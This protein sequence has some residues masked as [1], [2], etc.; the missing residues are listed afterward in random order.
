MLLSSGASAQEWRFYGG[1]SG[2]TRFSSLQQISRSNVKRLKRTWTYHMGEGDR[3]GNE[4]DRHHVA[5]FESTPLVIDGVLYFSTPSNRVIALDA[6]SGKEIWQFDP[7]AGHA[8]Q[9]EFFQHRG[10]SYWQNKNGSDRRIL[11][12]TFDGRLIALDAKTGKPCADFGTD[13]TVNLRAGVADAFPGAEYSVTSPPA[14]YQDLA[15][16][17]AAVPEYPSRGPIGVVRAFDVRSG[18]LVWTFHTIPEPGEMGHETWQED[19]WQNRT[20]ANVWSIMSVDTENG[21][22]FL[23]IGSASYD[24][25]GADRKGMDLFANSLVALD[26]ATGKLRWYFQMVHH[27]IWD[28]D[29]PA[30]PVLIS[31][32]RDGQQIPAVAQVT[33]MGFVFILDRLT[34]KPLFPVEERKV[35]ESTVPGEQAWPTQPFPLKP[36]PLVRQTLSED[37]ITEVTKESH[38]YCAEM[39]RSLKTRGMYTPYGLELTLVM[40]GTLG[41]GNWSGGAFDETSGYLFVNA[42]EFGAVGAMLPQA[43][44]APEKYRRGSKDGE[45]ARFWDNNQWPCQKPPWGTLNAV[46]VNKG[47]IIWKVPLGAM[48]GLKEKTGTPNLGGAIVTASGLVFIGA[49]MD[50]RFRAFD[51]KTGEELWATELEASAHATPTTYLGKKTGKQFVVIAAGGGGYF[52]GK[53]SDALAAFALPDK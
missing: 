25:Y 43:D 23:P 5:P 31:V 46:D 41:G 8:G 6:E 47:E 11:F 18:K 32:R 30:Q 34:G 24:F 9:R 44:G 3:G 14:I 40:P 42:N 13:G 48:D 38:E 33:K 36:P 21:L 37:D 39:A 16:T 51:T 20:G 2:G 15:I 45:Y 1:D 17:G 7:Q 12:G 49:T 19:G 10:V 28:Y 53:V 4:T 35:P 50:S 29:M 26:A 27:D 52:K 22:V